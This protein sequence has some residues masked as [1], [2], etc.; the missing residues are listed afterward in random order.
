MKVE[1]L[2]D[3]KIEGKPKHL[4]PGDSLL[5]T[6]PG[7]LTVGRVA[8]LEAERDDLRSRLSAWGLRVSKLE[9][10]IRNMAAAESLDEAIGIAWR[11]GALNEEQP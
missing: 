4:M 9:Q 2:I 10:T 5:F 1:L 6:A 7:Q 11:S 8:I 3:G